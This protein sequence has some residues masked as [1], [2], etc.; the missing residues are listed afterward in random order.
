MSPMGGGG[1]RSLL[2][3]LKFDGN[4]DHD[5]SDTEIVGSHKGVYAGL[6]VANPQPGWRYQWEVR[7]PRDVQLA[8]QRG[9]QV[10]AQDDPEGAAWQLASDYDSDLPSQLDSSDVYQDVVLMKMPEHKYRSLLEQRVRENQERLTGSDTAFLDGVSEA[11]ASSA[12]SGGR[13]VAT[14]WATREHSTA[15]KQGDETVSTHAPT[16]I[17]RE[18]I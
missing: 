1:D 11:E 4:L 9:W 15:V 8:R 13:R 7:S 16:G 10:I 12:H 18:N 3:Y 6:N 14:R 2:R 5:D 17:I